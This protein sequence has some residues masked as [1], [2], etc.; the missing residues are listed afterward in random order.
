MAEDSGKFL[1]PNVPEEFSED[2]LKAKV[3]GKIRRNVATHYMWGAPL[4][5]LEVELSSS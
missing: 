2:G 5:T 3:R 4:E 1:P